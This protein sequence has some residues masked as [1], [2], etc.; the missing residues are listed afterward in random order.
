MLVTINMIGILRII[1]I[2]VF[3]IKNNYYFNVPTD[4]F[5]NTQL[6]IQALADVVWLNVNM[7]D[8]YNWKNK[9]ILHK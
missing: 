3:V 8:F 1:I 9:Q 5:S 7:D 4:G 2:K 6:Q